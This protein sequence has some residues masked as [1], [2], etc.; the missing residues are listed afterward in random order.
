LAYGKLKQTDL[1][2]NLTA[3]EEQAERDAQLEHKQKLKR[4]W[5]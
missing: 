5:S 2:L 1:K 4:Q 3:N